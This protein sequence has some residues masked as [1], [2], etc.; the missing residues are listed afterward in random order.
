[1]TNTLNLD[2]LTA[3]GEKTLII[4]GE[5]HTAAEITVEAYID[6]V[7]RSKR[8]A[9]DATVDEKLEEAILFLK[10]IFP[11]ISE[12]VLRKLPLSHLN[13]VIDFALA[14][15]ADIAKVV[16]EQASVTE[17]AEGNA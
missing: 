11:S 3:G 12:S 2:E 17:T 13:R 4:K 7:K 14:A 9:A 10:E 8:I 15:P 16:G 5:S 6:R 1:V